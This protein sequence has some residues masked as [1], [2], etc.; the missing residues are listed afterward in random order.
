MP[1]WGAGEV[2]ESHRAGFRAGD[3]VWGTFGWQDYC[4]AGD[5][6]SFP[7]A[8]IPDEM[9]LTWPLGVTGITGVTAFIGMLDLARPKVGET[10]VVSAAA[11]STGSVAAQLAKLQG[12]RVIGIAGG[13]EK[14]RFLRDE[15]GLDAAIDYKSEPLRERLAALCPNG[16]D[17]YYDNV[18]GP[19]LDDL[20]LHMARRGRIVL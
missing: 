9:P 11:G 19:I 15:L 16:V 3:R 12:A 6:G 4:T 8:K 2:I 5:R 20:I 7:L 17:V 1:A 10:V 14:C 18:G 13:T